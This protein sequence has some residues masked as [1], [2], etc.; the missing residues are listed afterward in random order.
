MAKPKSLDAKL[1]AIHANP[2]CREFILA[3][4]KDADMALG[5]GAGGRSPEAHAGEVRFKT[6]EEY[7][8]QM[9]LIT[10]QGLVDIMLMSASTS[11]ALTIHERL[12]DDSAVTPAVRANDTTDIHLARGSSYAEHPAQPFR[13]MSIDHAQCGHLDCSP[14]ERSLGA[15]LGLYS[16]TFNNDLGHD[17]ASLERF[18]AF[19][20]EAERK[21]FRYFLEV[22]DPNVPNVVPPDVLP[23]YL[24]DMITRMLAG[25]SPAG[26][27]DFLKIVYHG[28]RAMEELVRFD[29]SLVVGILGGGSGTTRDAF[30]LLHD[31][32]KYGARVALFG[33]KINHAENQLAFVQVLRLIVDG[34]IG[35]VEAVKAYHAV[36]QRLGIASIRSLDDDLQ[37]TDTATS[38]AGTSKSVTVLSEAPIRN[39]GWLRLQWTRGGRRR[40]FSEFGLSVPPRGSGGEAGRASRSGRLDRRPRHERVLPHPGRRPSGFRPDGRHS[41]TRLPQE[42]AGA[43]ALKT[44]DPGRRLTIA[45]ARSSDRTHSVNVS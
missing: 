14:E 32:Q 5:L 30:Q 11:Y 1:A 42:A 27:P 26:R 28:P 25:V 23:G 29:P 44:D 45:A 17:L 35:P 4:A 7:R 24:N 41:A 16:V 9:R 8:E 3:D 13:T 15:N 39:D 21:S 43:R 22:F 33:R 19:R 6:V 12:F 18:H 38:Y 34:V 20:E 37:L 36:L 10:R 2:N 40:P 31:A